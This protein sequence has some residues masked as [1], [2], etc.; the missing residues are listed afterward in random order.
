MPTKFA[1]VLAQC[2]LGVCYLVTVV[3]V[4]DVI[5]YKDLLCEKQSYCSYFSKVLFGA[6]FI[7]AF[8]MF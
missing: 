4:G 5:Y 8:I 1:E 6:F 2:G 7:A 3:L